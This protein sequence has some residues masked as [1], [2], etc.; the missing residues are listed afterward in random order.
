MKKQ[1]TCGMCTTSRIEAKHRVFKLYLNSSSKLC[2]LFKVFKQLEAKEV[3]V[4][5]DE[6]EKLT[7]KEDQQFEKSLLIKHFAP[8]YSLYVLAKLKEQLNESLNYK[9]AKVQKTW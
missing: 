9:F 2:E 8:N 5:K 4:F 1:F 6:V 3:Y 7:K